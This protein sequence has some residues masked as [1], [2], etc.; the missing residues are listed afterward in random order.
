MKFFTKEVKIALVAVV[1]I[2]ILF[3]GMNF[4]K[5]LS[6]FSEDNTY[7]ISFKDITGLGESD[8]IYADGF[9]VGVVKGI[10]YNFDNNKE[11]LVEINVNK[12]M[13]IPKGSSAEIVADMLGNV[14]VNLL[15]A[16][17]TNGYLRPNGIVN[18]AINA[19][20]LGK[21]ANMVPSLQKMLPKLDSIL[22]SVNTL[23]A[24]PA[25]TQSMSNVQAITSDLTTTTKQLNTIM[26]TLNNSVPGMVAKTNGILDNTNT[27]TANLS[28]LDVAG[29]LAKVDQTL[30]SV[31]AF[32][33]K[34]N[35]SDGSLGLFMNDPMLYNNL[36]ATMRNADSLM[37]DLKANP[38]R[39]VHF[40]VF[41]SK[42]N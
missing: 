17:D 13:R 28:T 11:I 30:T 19:G 21:A 38:K 25:L 7:Y 10:T 20:A 15:L 23:L 1:A 14:R 4:L 33:D 22:T 27:L 29:T 9:K 34:L 6:I 5:G 36:N 3:F 16:H 39:Y 32:T 8:P 31:Q 24:D 26:A 35:G 41:G 2:I 37:I 40:S 12:K 18:G 42:G